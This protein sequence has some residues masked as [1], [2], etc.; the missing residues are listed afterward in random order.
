MGSSR[1]GVADM[2]EGRDGLGPEGRCQDR[3]TQKSYLEE[4]APNHSWPD[5]KPSGLP[6]GGE[7]PVTGGVRVDGEQSLGRDAERECV[8]GWAVGTHLLA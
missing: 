5:G 7:L 4:P 2:L 3:W 8:G 6:L 1:A